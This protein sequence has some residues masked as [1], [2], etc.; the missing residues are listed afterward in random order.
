MNE[1][2]EFIKDRLDA[3]A[4]ELVMLSERIEEL[5]KMPKPKQRPKIA[6]IQI[7]LG[8]DLVEALEFEERKEA[9]I[10]K[11]KRWLGDLWISIND[12]LK[13]YGAKW[14]KAGK[15]SRWEIK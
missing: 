5:M 8:T 10:I 12:K 14:I 6:D 7:S 11:P 9:I 13:S 15:D 4:K 3:I 2:L 1:E